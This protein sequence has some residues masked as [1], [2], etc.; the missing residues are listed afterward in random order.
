MAA[1]AGSRGATTDIVPN[2][3]LGPLDSGNGKDVSKPA[4]KLVACT[5]GLASHAPSQLMLFRPWMLAGIIWSKP[6]VIV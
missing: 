1:T 2:P 4:S 3:T 5:T 6:V